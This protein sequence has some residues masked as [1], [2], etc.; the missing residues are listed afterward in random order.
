MNGLNIE[1]PSWGFVN[2][3][4]RF[5]VFPQQG[6]PRTV[7]EKLDDAAMVHKMTGIAPSVALHIPWDKV[8]DY[9]ALQAHATS[10]GLT[11]GAINPNLFHHLNNIATRMSVIFFRRID[12]AGADCEFTTHSLVVKTFSHL[13]TA[14][15]LSANKQIFIHKLIV[16]NRSV[17]KS[18]L[19]YIKKR[20]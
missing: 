19:A 5:R 3:G 6:V 12:Y 2:T 1:I 17:A 13:T 7:F 11:L 18:S 20:N 4:T 15:I 8:D 10:L 16:P 14:D 9:A